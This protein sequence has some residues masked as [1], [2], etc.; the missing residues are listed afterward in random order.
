MEVKLPGVS[1]AEVR[2]RPNCRV[3]RAGGTMCVHNLDNFISG[4]KKKHHRLYPM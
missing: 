3:R 1:T 4:E 2:G